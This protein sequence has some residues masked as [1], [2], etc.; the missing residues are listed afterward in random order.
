MA[1][2]S[3]YINAYID[4]TMGM[5]HENMSTI[6]QLKTQAKLSSDLVKSKLDEN[7]KLQEELEKVKS[8]LETSK[9]ELKNQLDSTLSDLENNLKS[10]RIE[11]ENTRK[12]DNE[13]I[14][15]ARKESK[16]WE[17]EYNALKNK[18]STIDTLTNQ[19]NDVKKQLIDK[20]NEF[21]ILKEKYDNLQNSVVELE[22]VK[23]LLAEKEQQIE[24]LEKEN[25]KKFSQTVP[26][27]NI[28]NKNIVPPAPESEEK[29]DDF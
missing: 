29:A 12:V 3:G 8:E 18:V 14:N 19:F 28:N 26:K 5:L 25:I 9:S 17:D 16:K 20:N 22:K 24:I 23:K 13:Q 6:L 7:A 11:L 2:S 4:T 27:K 10:T 21:N 1:D 15:N